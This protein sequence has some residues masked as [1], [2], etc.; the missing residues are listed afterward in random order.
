[1]SE[2]VNLNQYRKTRRRRKAEAEASQNRLRH[3]RT[4]AERNRD[5]ADRDLQ[6]SAH[7]GKRLEQVE[8]PPD[9][10]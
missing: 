4:K 3:G 10:D 9:S 1:M 5:A 7:D 8:A 6:A 2:I